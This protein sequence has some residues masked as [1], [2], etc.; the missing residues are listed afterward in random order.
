MVGLN[1]YTLDEEE[2]FESLKVDPRI[3]A[4]QC[5]SLAELRK[6]RDNDA[7]SRGLDSLRTAAAGT[8]NLLHPMKEVLA[9]HATGGEVAH[10]LR[11]VWGTYV[12]NDAF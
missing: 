4:D 2:P 3:E 9:A 7:V 6:G 5:E 10:A 8:D 1:K 12:P 11:D